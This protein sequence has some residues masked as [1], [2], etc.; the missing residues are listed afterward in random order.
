MPQKRTQLNIRLTQKERDRL[1]RN[2]R[3]CGLTNSAYLRTL[4]NK[5][6]PKPLPPE[7][8][9]DIQNMLIDL[10]ASCDDP[11]LRTRIA[12]IKLKHQ[13]AYTAPEKA[14]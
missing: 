5:R 11:Q 13:Q 10:Y 7:E 14:G 3:R 12:Q 8:Y 9:Y 4:I 1:E 6:Q 2:A